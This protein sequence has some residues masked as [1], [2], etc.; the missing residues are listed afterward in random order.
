MS[1]GGVFP[2][3]NKAPESE[4]NSD[5]RIFIKTAALTG[6]AAV[7]GTIGGLIGGGRFLL[8]PVLRIVAQTGIPELFTATALMVVMGAALFA[9]RPISNSPTGL[10][11]YLPA[12]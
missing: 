1:Q 11:T 8:R 7:V 10:S 9:D 12:G 6:V 5:R 4:V 2:K 3:G